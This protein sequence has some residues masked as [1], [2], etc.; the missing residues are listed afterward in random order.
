MSQFL[1]V[2]GNIIA[3]HQKLDQN[4]FIRETNLMAVCSIL[5]NR[6]FCLNFG[7]GIGSFVPYPKSAVSPRLKSVVLPTNKIVTFKL[8]EIPEDST[9]TSYEILKSSEKHLFL[10]FCLNVSP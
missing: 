8:R 9:R 7:I 10:R 1:I 6:R 5:Q 3:N 2:I 4:A